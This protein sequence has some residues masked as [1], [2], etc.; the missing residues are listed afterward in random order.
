M[1]LNRT[2]NPLDR[3]ARNDENENWDKIESKINQ[4][5]KS[6]NDMVIE[7]GSSDMEVVQARGGRPTLNTRLENIEEDVIEKRD[8][9]VEIDMK[10]LSQNVK[11]AMTGGSVAVVGKDSVGKINVKDK[12]ISHEKT[13]F[14]IT[15]KNLFDG[16][17]LN[18]LTYFANSQ[19]IN[20]P[21]STSPSSLI[22]PLDSSGV[23]TVTKYEGGNRFII[24]LLDEYPFEDNLPMEVSLI[25]DGNRIGNKE[26]HTFT[27]TNNKKYLFVLTNSN[28]GEPPKVQI[29]E[30]ST[31]T[32]YEEFKIGFKNSLNEIPLVRSKGN[33]FDG[34]YKDVVLYGNN[35]DEP[36]F[37]PVQSYGS[38]R[39][40]G[41]VVPVE[42]NKTYYVKVYDKENSNRFRIGLNY[43]EPSF[44]VKGSD[45]TTTD[46][47]PSH[48]N[49]IDKRLVN[50][51]GLSEYS[52]SSE[53]YNYAVIHLDSSGNEPEV[54]LGTSYPPNNFV[55]SKVI[56]PSYIELPPNIGETEYPDQDAK[57]RFVVEMNQYAKR[58]GME[59]T[60]YVE[61][62][63][64]PSTAEQTMTAYDILLMGIQAMSYDR[65]A[66]IWNKKTY[67]IEVK[68]PDA[69]IQ[70]INT[71]VTNSSLESDYYIFGGKTGRIVSVE[72]SENLVLIANAPNDRM[73]VGAVMGAESSA[74]RFTAMKQMY[75][76]SKEILDGNTPSDTSIDADHG[77][78]CLLPVSYLSSFERYDIPIVFSKDMK[79]KRHPAS[80]S[81]VMS[82]MIILDN[83]VNLNEKITIK[84]SDVKGG[85]GNVFNEG[86]VITVEDALY[87]MMLPSSNTATHAAARHVGNR[88]LNIDNE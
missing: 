2:P 13:D 50:N 29:E 68:G 44:Q 45:L 85:T 5:E 31:P 9:N 63:G 19:T 64:Y 82:A 6:V 3:K 37:V 86:D 46:P 30:G 28:G 78:T 80:L 48:Y 27:N 36:V 51:N 14:I 58:I 67:D 72:P 69:R 16:A 38:T 22:T 25:H 76:C 60:N 41:F 23:Y 54:W 66:R 17:Y 47:V 42:H 4:V 8:K 24:C 77:A 55:N 49:L 71:T 15:G 73:F 75:D 10:D 84:E 39:G 70:T 88:L 59:D 57:D 35:I 20:T 7:S 74:K 33:L 43:N 21:S 65:L 1:K 32:G 56:D 34:E 62:A 52:F 61:P 18:D 83:I 79:S 53:E 11:E 87:A 26:H 12:A 81:K 40:R